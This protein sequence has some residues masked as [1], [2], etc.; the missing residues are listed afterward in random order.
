MR[1]YCVEPGFLPMD[2]P[3]PNVVFMHGEL[4]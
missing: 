3:C 2:R 4:P 1:S